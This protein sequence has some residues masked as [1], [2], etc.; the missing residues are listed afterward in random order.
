M[1]TPEIAKLCQKAAD[2]IEEHGH[3]KG[4][5]EDADGCVC[6]FGAINLA[7][8]GNADEWSGEEA[9]LAQAKALGFDSVNDLLHWNDAPERTQAEVLARLR[10][11]V[12]Q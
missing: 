7:E 8:N 11:V 1:V 2:L 5:F 9:A 3:A 12:A 4:K 10:S 6:L